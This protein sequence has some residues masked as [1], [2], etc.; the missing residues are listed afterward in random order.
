M[1]EMLD[2]EPPNFSDSQI[3]AMDKIKV[4]PSPSP[5]KA[6]VR[7]RHSSGACVILG[8]SMKEHA[9][10]DYLDFARN[11]RALL[12][13]ISIHDMHVRTAGSIT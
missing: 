2:G 13:I 12:Y 9:K 10:L 7:K 8:H 11:I 4:N 1:I 5:A 6:E 3:I